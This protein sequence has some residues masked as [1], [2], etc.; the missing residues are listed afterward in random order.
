MQPTVEL[1]AEVTYTCIVTYM[2][3][4]SPCEMDL[5]D[6]YQSLPAGA[7]GSNRS[8]SQHAE[9]AGWKLVGHALGPCSAGR[10]SCTGMRRL[11]LRAAPRHPH[12]APVLGHHIALF[13]GAGLPHRTIKRLYW[14][15]TLLHGWC[16][17]LSAN[18]RAGRCM[19]T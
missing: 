6:Q 7:A 8:A 5:G 13:Q 3:L 14:N 17:E 19:F 2:W 1:T 11:C 9:P 16:M 18:E 15:S 4:V 12:A 10:A